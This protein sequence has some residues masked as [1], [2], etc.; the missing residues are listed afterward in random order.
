MSDV[1]IIT[2]SAILIS[3]FAT[4]NHEMTAYHWQIIVYLAWFSSLTHLAILTFLRR[5]LYQHRI[6]RSWRLIAMLL[7][8]AGL[9]AA[10]LPTAVTMVNDNPVWETGGVHARCLFHELRGLSLNSPEMISM[11]VSVVVVTSSFL[12]RVIRMHR[13]PT[14]YMD[15]PR[16][17]FRNMLMNLLERSIP[18][19]AVTTTTILGH[20]WKSFWSQSG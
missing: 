3:G 17:W 13:T 9:V 1:Q 14:S 10:L 20:P 6:T 4:L 8:V 16:A 11:I 7:L 19:I 2:G 15:R 5:Y 18:R 12:T